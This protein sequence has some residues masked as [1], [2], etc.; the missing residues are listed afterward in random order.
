VSSALHINY[1]K[2]NKTEMQYMMQNAAPKYFEE[3]AL[4]HRYRTLHVCSVAIC[5]LRVCHVCAALHM[6]Q[7]G[8]AMMPRKTS[9]L[10][11][12]NRMLRHGLFRSALSSSGTADSKK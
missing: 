3:T 1:K 5:L 6:V 8:Y 11:I 7:N 12:G 10:S 4:L 9:F 2:N